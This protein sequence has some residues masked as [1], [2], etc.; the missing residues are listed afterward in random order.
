MSVFRQ[1]ANVP[2]VVVNNIIDAAAVVAGELLLAPVSFIDNGYAS[3][4]SITSAADISAINFTI[5]GTFN[6][7]NIVE[8]LAGANTNTVSSLNLFDTISSIVSSGVLAQGY[9]IGSNNNI[10][11]IMNLTYPDAITNILNISNTKDTNTINMTNINSMI[12]SRAAAGAWNAPNVLVYGLSG[13]NTLTALTVANLTNV[14]RPDNFYA[15]NDP[16]A[17]ITQAQLNRGFVTNTVYP[18]SSIIVCFLDSVNTTASFVE[19]NQS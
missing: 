13:S 5:T 4:I 9:S 14:T 1:S 16:A 8:V 11:V 7:N 17:N 15:I 18:F 19:I 6:G 10:A 2:A 3:S 12:T